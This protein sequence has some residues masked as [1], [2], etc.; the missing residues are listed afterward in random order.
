MGRHGDAAPDE[1]AGIAVHERPAVRLEC[2]EP[3]RVPPLLQTAGYARARGAAVD[4][5]TARQKSLTAFTD[6]EAAV[7]AYRDEFAVLDG[8]ALD[9]RRSRRLIA[10]RA[11][12]CLNRLAEEA[13]GDS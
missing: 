7:R 3:M 4:A 1:P 6:D 9:A 12:T 2:S 11:S 5:R 13:E 8:L 10:Q